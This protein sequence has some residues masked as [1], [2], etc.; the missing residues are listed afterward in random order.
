MNK[1]GEE[2]PSERK[3]KSS[4]AAVV[5]NLP[6]TLDTPILLRRVREYL[7]TPGAPNLRLS[8]GWLAKKLNIDE[9]ELLGALAY[10]VRDGLLEMHWEVY[11]PMC[12]GG[13]GDIGSLRHARGNVECVDCEASFDLHLDRDV[14][15][16]FSAGERLRRDRGEEVLPGADEEA[17]H[18]TRGLDLLLIPAFWELF[19]GEA[20]ADDESLRIGRVAI[21]FTDLRSSTAMYAER[22]DPRAYRLVRDHFAILGKAINRNKGALVKTIGDA[23]MASF[24]SGADAVRAA[25]EAQAEL[26]ARA[27]DTQDMGGELVLKA[28]VHAGAC[29]A[30][31]LNDRLDFFGGAVNTAAR[32]QGL[33]C[34][35]DVVVTDQVIADIEGE[36]NRDQRQFRIE[37]SFDARLRGLPKP[38]RVH[39]LIVAT[40]SEVS[41]LGPHQSVTARF[42]R[43]VGRK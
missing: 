43:L 24:S 4:T 36:G 40:G 19:S 14:R 29:L 37:K 11:C 15:V 35:N 41:G 38:V 39:R 33:S 34:G 6:N 26:R 42:F 8:P 5:Q 28:G 9:R 10:G 13:T 20:P 3:P 16:T 2:F 22:G 12:G 17:E 23:V 18:T 7:L 30:V 25:F 1:A 27:Q 31:K 21:L 32:V